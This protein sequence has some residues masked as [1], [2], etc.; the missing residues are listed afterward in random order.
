MKVVIKGATT[1]S[2]P[3]TIIEKSTNNI[4]FEMVKPLTSFSLVLI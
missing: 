2:E 3:F 1:S 4:T